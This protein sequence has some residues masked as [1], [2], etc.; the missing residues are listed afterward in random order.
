MPRDMLPECVTVQIRDSLA[1]S[2]TNT[3]MGLVRI[4]RNLDLS[5]FSNDE[6]VAY[7]RRVILSTPVDNI[8]VRGK[9]YYLYSNEFTAVLT[10][11]RSSRGIITAKKYTG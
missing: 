10:I 2:F 8:E 6:I 1:E 7:C 5:G 3:E 11:N 4:A 9:N